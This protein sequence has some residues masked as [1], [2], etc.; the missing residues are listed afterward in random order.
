MKLKIITKKEIVPLF[1]ILITFLFAVCFYHSPCL[2]DK[3]PSHW[4]ARGEIDS[5]SS[6]PFA[7]F[8]YPAVTFVLYL[9]MTFLPLIDPLRKNYE[10]FALPYYVIR[11]ALVLFLTF[12]YFYTVLVAFGFELGVRY[13]MISALSLLFVVLGACLPKI[14]RNYFVGVRTPWT[15]QSDEVWKE[16]HNLGAKTMIIA[17]IL[18]FFSMFFGLYAFWVFL[19]LILIGGLTPVVYS[20]FIYRK[21]GLF[22]VKKK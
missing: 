21:L 18:S 1:I 8:F 16:T 11:L 10:K 4:N 5:Y 20:Y 2:P 15:L 17:G 7:L 9:L 6:K 13:I 22:N 14:K 12:L 19:G 3:I